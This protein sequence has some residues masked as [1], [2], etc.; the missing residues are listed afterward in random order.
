MK[1]K[2]SV[3]STEI[4]P[5]LSGIT[6]TDKYLAVLAA[7]EDWHRCIVDDCTFIDKPNKIARKTTH[8][9]I[10]HQLITDNKAEGEKFLEETEKIFADIVARF[11]GWQTTTQ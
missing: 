9:Y 7:H 11:P 10:Q 2:R 1:T 4:P 3:N 6:T 5:L 8:G